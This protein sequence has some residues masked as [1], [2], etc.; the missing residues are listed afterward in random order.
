MKLRA[1]V[2]ALLGG[3]C[4]WNGSV[5]GQ[6]LP[7]GSP[8]DALSY[9]TFSDT[10]D[11]TSDLGSKPL[12]YSNL[13]VSELGDGTALVVD[14]TNAAWLAYPVIDGDLT[15]L[16]IGAPGSLAFWF[17]PSWSG[18]N[19]GG[20]G[21]GVWGRLIEA[22]TY[23]TNASIG[24]WSLYT[25][26]AGCNLYFS[27]QTNNGTSAVYLSAP[28]AWTT[29][30]WH[31]V[32]LTYS[33][34]N[35][36][37][38]LDGTLAT[39]QVSGVTISPPASALTN[40]FSIGSSDN[41]SNQAYGMFDDL[42]SYGYVLTA[43]TI[44]N[45]FSGSGVQYWANPLN[46][47]NLASAPFDTPYPSPGFRAIM[48]TGYVHLVSFATNCATN[49]SVWMANVTAELTNNGTMDLTFTIAGG[50]PDVP[51]DVFATGGL[52]GNSI[53]NA[54]WVWMGQGY[55]CGRYTIT[56]LPGTTAMFV[57][58]TPQ[59]S[60][61]DGLTDAFEALVSKT[62]P[63]DPDTYGTG[64]L[65]SW[66]F[67]HFGTN[68][69]DPYGDADGDGW[70]N[71]QEYQ[72]GTDP[73]HF[74][75]PP[76][77]Q[78]VIAKVDST[79]TNI[80]ITWTSGGG[81]VTNYAIERAVYDAPEI[82]ASI[83]GYTN[84]TS[85]AFHDTFYYSVIGAIGPTPE[86]FVRAY[87]TNGSSAVSAGATPSQSALNADLAVVRGPLGQPY[88]VLTSAP[89]DLSQVL[90]RFDFGVG[91]VSLYPSNF[92][93]GVAP[94]GG[95][96]YPLQA[97]PEDS[98]V[99]QLFATNGSFGETYNADENPF[100]D[101]GNNE[102]AWGP[103]SA[104]T[105]VDARRHL[106]ENLKFLLRSAGR[107]SAFAYAYPQTPT[108]N[109]ISYSSNLTAYPETDFVR[110][111][112]STNYEYYGFHYFSPALG[113]SVREELRPVQENFIWSNFVFNAETYLYAPEG[114][115]FDCPAISVRLL[116]DPLAS[117]YSGSGTESNLPISLVNSSDQYIY[118][119]GVWPDEDSCSLSYDV[120]MGTNGTGKMLM[121]SGVKNCFGLNIASAQVDWG[122]TPLVPG[123]PSNQTDQGDAVNCWPKTD[124]PSLST[125]DYYFVSQTPYFRYNAAYGTSR[126]PLPGSPDFTVTNASPLLLTG[127][128]QSIS[129]SGWA[130]QAIGNGY[131]NKFAYLEQYFDKAYM[132]GTN[133]ADTNKP[134]GVLSPYGDF[135]PTDPGSVGL[136]TMRDIDT[137][138]QGTGVVNVIKLQLD[139]NHDGTMDLSL[140][141]PD[142][143]SQGRP[144]VFWINNDD[145]NSIGQD[146]PGE[147]SEFPAP[148]CEE[149]FITC[150]R[151]LEDFARLWVCG[152][153]AL[154]NDN[155]QVTLSW[156][157]ITSG[158]PSI[159]VFNSVE[160]DGGVA[161]LKDATVAQQQV[162]WGLTN[163]VATGPGIAF[164]E[165]TNGGTFTFPQHYFMSIGNKYL[166]FEGASV[167]AGQ[168]VMRVCQGSN[169][170]AETS[171]WLDLRDVKSM[172]EQIRVENVS[173]D[174][175][176]T[177]TST[178]VT[179]VTLSPNV[180]EPKQ[181]IV[182][183]HGW[184]MGQWEYYNF[185]E[186]MFKRLYWQGYRGRFAAVRWPTLSHDDFDVPL[187]DFFTYNK[188]EF[189]AHQCG[190]ALAG[191]F[192]WLRGR[193]PDYTI[194]VCSH[195]MGGIVMMQTLK[196]AL[197]SGWEDI[198]NYVLMQAAVPA[199]CYDPLLANYAPFMAAEVSSPT[200]DTYRGYP[201]P[202]DLAL[203][204]QMVNFFNT[205]DFALATGTI[206]G[207]SVSWESNEIKY[208]PDVFYSSDGSNAL[209]TGLP[210]RLLTDP[211]EIMA[212]VSRPRSKAVGAQPGVAGVI[213]GGQVD[214]TG[215]FNF[216][217]DK[218]EHSAQFNYA[219]QAAWGF[220]SS[221]LDE[222]LQ[223]P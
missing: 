176:N 212:F 221:L 109:G 17:A 182:F 51:Y 87:F 83:V 130:K 156:T 65:D 41:G 166:L 145:D 159:K 75:T 94:L 134:T 132:M 139:V 14:S 6:D 121:N 15:N 106:K 184:R 188:S 7:P 118:Y 181:L 10:N 194:G 11:W 38:Y 56:N 163:S 124:V 142:N 105:F 219:I 77:P 141:G 13:G 168:L 101:A 93:N 35:A 71:L 123:V 201:G 103:S 98:T 23:T 205:N 165:I 85:F 113:Y 125:V 171:A 33:P 161:Y 189:R 40:G 183:V 218:T 135:M 73:N 36:S 27:A 86:Y 179:N 173:D 146:I 178:Y 69:F 192:H 16:V 157:N 28:I 99:Y 1:C 138:Q 126:P 53:T 45:F 154:T 74:D 207:K 95:A 129:I 153:P 211:R 204:G 196:A 190:V 180:G 193:F 128:G 26:P 62:D 136:I 170:L 216:L 187:R 137:G 63:Y 223:Q 5:S 82:Y 191:Y 206:L 143:T 61:G 133:G 160:A 34:T 54:Q 64:V 60:D 107:N 29:N 208:K 70:T 4:V 20:S 66:Q 9:W 42:E 76:P 202:I 127:L 18:T 90:I 222:L 72:S 30:K 185:S 147:D 117:L 149:K 104:Y 100:S 96:S 25:D 217:G 52:V 19:S 197:D 148:N 158:S 203:R 88:A 110:Q 39:N 80:T 115:A 174:T 12:S 114:F 8:Y 79:G 150:Q 84:S 175:P 55:T 68:V 111:P 44:S 131:S 220:Y 210:N 152:L 89:A 59:D 122:T 119:G 21:P 151:D 214:L 155:Y 169:V 47:A 209:W 195:S 50:S 78:N 213:G 120:G 198:D 199:H 46:T 102:E 22:G 200:P 91:E 164:G 97:L 2:A 172:Y 67:I 177:L 92:V 108:L 162:S 186:T 116:A 112:G 167:G 48:G 3:W 144:Y 43:H 215:N 81:P 49:I 58:G 140:A 32:I 37:L 24:W 57:L 31:L